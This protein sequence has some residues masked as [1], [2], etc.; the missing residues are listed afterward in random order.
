M[1]MHLRLNSRLAVFIMF[2]NYSISVVRKII[3]LPILELTLAY[4]LLALDPTIIYSAA[5]L[6][7]DYHSHSHQA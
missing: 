7:T 5:N 2:S 6:G 3:K 1:E 4:Q